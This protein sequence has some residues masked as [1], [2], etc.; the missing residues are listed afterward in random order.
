MRI[1]T[2]LAAAALTAAFLPA[3]AA[4][5]ESPLPQ[6]TQQICQAQNAQLPPTASVLV[7]PFVPEAPAAPQAAQ[8]AQSF[9]VCS[10]R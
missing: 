10:G 3:P 6:L 2:V 4:A 1:A 5:A 7:G 9:Q 8:P